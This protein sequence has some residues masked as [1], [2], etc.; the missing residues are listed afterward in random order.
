V[1]YVPPS[2]GSS[3]HLHVYAS[4]FAWRHV[5][6]AIRVAKCV[7]Y[8]RAKKP[9]DS[10]SRRTWP[11]VVSTS[12]A[13]CLPSGGWGVARIVTVVSCRGL[14]PRNAVETSY[15]WAD[16]IGLSRGTFAHYRLS[17]KQRSRG[18]KVNWQM[19]VLQEMISDISAVQL[20]AIIV[21]LTF[22]AYCDVISAEP[23]WHLL[24][25]TSWFIF[26]C[27]NTGRA[28]RQPSHRIGRLRGG[29]RRCRKSQLQLGKTLPDCGRQYYSSCQVS[30]TP[31][32]GSACRHPA[33]SLKK[34]ATYV[35]SRLW[36]DRE[37]ST[38]RRNLSTLHVSNTAT[39][40]TV[41]IKPELNPF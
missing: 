3:I 6:G 4:G 12:A 25:P 30:Y 10:S 40:R 11:E 41:V 5:A 1:Q 15:L 17:D 31:C 18:Y 9:S 38:C 33:R 29:G 14:A 20:Y 34:P 22:F 36:M 35:T 26:V 24:A 16:K 27:C 32:L 39:C 28:S 8:A 19:K 2:G 7:L 37:R 13:D 21:V 23:R